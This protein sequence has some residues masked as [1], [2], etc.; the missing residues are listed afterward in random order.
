MKI[1]DGFD[2]RPD[3]EFKWKK[4]DTAGDDH[5]VAALQVGR[6]RQCAGGEENLNFVGEQRLHAESAALQRDVF[7]LQAVLLKD[8][9]VI[10]PGQN[11]IDCRAEA[12]VGGAES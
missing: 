8:L 7:R 3:D 1:G 10:C 11:R 9:G 5:A 2:L 4:I 12:A 6:D